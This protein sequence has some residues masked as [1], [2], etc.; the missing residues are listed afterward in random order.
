[1][2]RWTRGRM[3]LCSH[4]C[5][6]TASEAV[7]TVVLFRILRAAL[8]FAALALPCPRTFDVAIC[9]VCQH[10]RQQNQDHNHSV[11]QA[12]A[13]EYQTVA[14]ETRFLQ[15]WHRGLTASAGVLSARWAWLPKGFAQ[16][17]FPGPRSL[18]LVPWPSFPGHHF[19]AV[20]FPVVASYTGL[21]AFFYSLP[22]FRI[23][24]SQ[25]CRFQRGL[26][27]HW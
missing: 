21:P 8:L 17:L 5:S 16:R 23:A 15:H 2:L 9:G 1:M 19:I 6:L 25:P 11:E 4:L 20:S 13:G 3:P 27:G 18:A 7:A 12:Q 10:C 22:R 14:Q 26:V 24:H